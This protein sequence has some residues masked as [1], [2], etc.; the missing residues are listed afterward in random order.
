MNMRPMRRRTRWQPLAALIAAAVFAISACGGTS[1]QQVIAGSQADGLANTERLDPS[2][3][4]A[5]EL[6]VAAMSAEVAESS[7]AVVS[8][9]A[10]DDVSNLM[11]YEIDEH[12]N[13]RMSMVQE[14]GPDDSDALSSVEILMVDG[15][16]YARMQIPEELLAGSDIEIPTGWMTVGRETFELLGISCGPPLPGSGRDGDACVPPNDVSGMAEFVLDASIVG[17]ETVR[18]V[19]TIRVRSALDFRSLMEMALGDDSDG[20]FVDLMLAMMPD[21]LPIELWVDDDLRI[22]RMSMDL[23]PDL[24]ALGEEL[25]QEIDEVPTVVVLMEF[26]DFGADITIEAPPPDEIVGEFG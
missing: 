13:M 12:G 3:L 24:E 19:E 26:S 22:H 6:V 1:D 23:T 11:I 17:P 7:V 8:T 16:G 25:G 14:T 15:V 20:S 2:E 5:R 10:G 18:G 9:D 21:E 4:S